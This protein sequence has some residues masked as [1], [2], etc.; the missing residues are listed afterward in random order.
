[1]VAVL[2]TKEVRLLKGF[3]MGSVLSIGGIIALYFNYTSPL[4]LCEGYA[5]MTEGGGG[6]RGCV[7]KHIGVS[8]HFLVC[9]EFFSFS[10]LDLFSVWFFYFLVWFFYF[11]IEGSIFV[12]LGCLL[13]SSLLAWC[14]V[15][16]D[17]SLRPHFVR[18]PLE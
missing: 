1:M 18:A 11:V 3:R 13:V 14:F 6:G 5:G 16:L 2:P 17:S 7:P 10:F 15:A 4:P 8:F 9:V 12:C